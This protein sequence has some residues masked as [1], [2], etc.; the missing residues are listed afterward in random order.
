MT[1]KYLAKLHGLERGVSADIFKTGDPH[2]PSKP[3]K[4]SFEG[5]EGEQGWHISANRNGHTAAEPCANSTAENK[6]RGTP[7]NPQNP[8]NLRTSVGPDHTKVRIVE[9][10]ATG[11]RYRRTFAHLQLKPPALVPE[12]RWRK[13]IQDGSK[14]LAVWG[15]QAESLAW[16]S[17]DLFG[18]HQPPDKPHPS[19]RRLSRYDCTG[20]CWLLEGRPVVALTADTAAIENPTGNLS[21]YRR[22]NK[23]ALGPLGDS[24]DDLK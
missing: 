24:L 5:F 6:K 21:T 7:T 2:I 3:S 1:N 9:I 11:L 20:L 19:Y 13:C 23:P 8:R 15:E 22:L 4:S 16:T 18:L 17:A 12:D 14:F 10:P